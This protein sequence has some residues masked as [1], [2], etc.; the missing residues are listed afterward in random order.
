MVIRISDLPGVYFAEFLGFARMVKESDLKSKDDRERS[1]WTL[2]P[3]VTP[4]YLA[5]KSPLVPES[6][7]ARLTC[8]TP[9][10]S[11]ASLIS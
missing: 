3:S 9:D 7:L 2:A 5:K 11:W 6:K 10:G 1:R 4:R 8:G